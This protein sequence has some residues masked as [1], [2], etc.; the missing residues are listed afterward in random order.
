MNI[1]REAGFSKAKQVNL[2]EA[3]I[4]LYTLTLGEIVTVDGKCINEG[5]LEDMLED[6]KSNY[7]WRHPNTFK[8]KCWKISEKLSNYIL[9]VSGRPY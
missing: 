5:I 4:V 7:R 3:E 9:Y 2:R 8:K 6:I 1:G